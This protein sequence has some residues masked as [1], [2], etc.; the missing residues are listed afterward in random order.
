MCLPMST[1]HFREERAD[2][3]EASDAKTQGREMKSKI[4]G[5]L[6]VVLLASLPANANTITVGTITT[7]P[8]GSG[9]VL[10]T[11]QIVF[12]NSAISSS[13]PT[14]FNLNDFGTLRTTGPLPVGFSFSPGVTFTLTTPLVGPSFGLPGF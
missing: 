1:S 14:S 5:L 2:D 3:A 11:Y 4:L 10:W 13:Q 7:A 9:G 8:D 12:S 6:A